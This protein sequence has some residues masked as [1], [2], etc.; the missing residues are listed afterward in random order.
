MSI[1]VTSTLSPT[2]YSYFTLILFFL[3][4][5]LPSSS[6]LSLLVS[7]QQHIWYLVARDVFEGNVIILRI[8]NHCTGQEHQNHTVVDSWYKI[9]SKVL[10]VDIPVWH[11]PLDSYT[12]VIA[13]NILSLPNLSV[14]VYYPIRSMH[15]VSH[16]V[17]VTS[18]GESLP[19]FILFIFNLL[20][21]SLPSCNFL[22]LYFCIFTQ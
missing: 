3:S 15:T 22:S 1:S 7:S 4:L 5:F 6:F 19:Y 16:C 11:W 10:G 9:F 21:I 12:R 13:F 8:A 2:W 14:T 18:L 20:P 17:M